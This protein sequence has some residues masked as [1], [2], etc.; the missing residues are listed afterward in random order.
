MKY[1]LCNKNKN[2]KVEHIINFEDMSEQF[3][4]L[5]PD[6]YEIILTKLDLDDYNLRFDELT[7]CFV[8]YKKE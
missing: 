6:Y 8:K 5:Y 1:V 7:N 3:F 2:L 4:Y